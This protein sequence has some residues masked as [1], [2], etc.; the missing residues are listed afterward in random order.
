VRWLE[1]RSLR[2]ALLVEHRAADPPLV[3]YAEYGLEADLW[4]DQISV[5]TDGRVHPA[6]TGRGL[7]SLLLGIAEDRAR[8]A[9]LAIGTRAAAAGPPAAAGGARP[10]PGVGG[11]R[12]GAAAR[13]AA[14]P[15]PPPPPPGREDAGAHAGSGG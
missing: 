15:P 6:W 1:L 8:R 3:A 5:H 13:A 2:D 9:T 10:P 12:G 4:T 11:A 7:A 14:R